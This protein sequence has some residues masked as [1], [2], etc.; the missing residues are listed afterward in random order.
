MLHLNRIILPFGFL[1]YYSRNS[2]V[3]CSI[4]TFGVMITIYIIWARQF[5]F[6]FIT[7][8]FLFSLITKTVF[9]MKKSDAKNLYFTTNEAVISIYYTYKALTESLKNHYNIF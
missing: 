3:L 8:L 7:A 1:L 2:L 6:S 9:A 5:Q 4:N